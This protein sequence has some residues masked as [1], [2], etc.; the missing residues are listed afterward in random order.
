MA[1]STSRQSAARQCIPKP[2]AP[3][4]SAKRSRSS[5]TA[6]P[7]PRRQ[8]PRCV[9]AAHNP[10]LSYGETHPPRNTRTYHSTI[11]DPGARRTSAVGVDRE[12]KRVG[13]DAG[14]RQHQQL[15]ARRRS[16]LYDEEPTVP[17]HALS[18]AAVGRE[19]RRLC[20]GTL[21]SVTLCLC[22]VPVY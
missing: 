15:L 22:F 17:P 21:A 8:V 14:R 4:C 5:S 7:P 9:V 10:T 6:P 3:Y 11:R 20:R 12:V 18:P 19:L 13:A 1:N 2:T 16:H